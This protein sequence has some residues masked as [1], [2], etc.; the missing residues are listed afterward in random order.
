MLNGSYSEWADVVIGVSQGSVL[1]PHSF[2]HL[3]KLHK[4]KYIASKVSKFADDIRVLSSVSKQED[5]KKLR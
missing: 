2:H 3:Y 4:Y 1:R 5:I